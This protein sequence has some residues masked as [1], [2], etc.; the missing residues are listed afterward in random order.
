MYYYSEHTHSYLFVPLSNCF[1][2]IL[3]NRM[4]RI[5]GIHIFLV[6]HILPSRRFL[7]TYSLAIEF[8]SIFPHVLISI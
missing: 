6:E 5:N 4:H 2:V 7:P 8:E 3:R 1:L